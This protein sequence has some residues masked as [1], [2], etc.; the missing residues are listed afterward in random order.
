MGFAWSSFIAQSYLL[1]LCAQAG[2]TSALVL[3]TDAPPPERSSLAFALATDDVMVFSDVPGR[4]SSVA[5]GLDD[6]MLQNGMKKHAGKDVDDSTDCACVGVD[7]VKGK[8]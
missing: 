3:S 6:V 5:R 8:S 2:L 4:S 1:A 7:L